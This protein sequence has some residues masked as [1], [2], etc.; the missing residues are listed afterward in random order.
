MTNAPEDLGRKNAKTGL[1][2]ASIAVGMVALSFAFVP[3]YRLFCQVTGLGGTPMVVDTNKTELSEHTI[4]VRFDSNVHRDLPWEFAPVQ[5]EVTVNLGEDRL[6]AYTSEN[7]SDVPV[8][9]ISNFNVTPLKAA[10]YFNKIQCFCFE[11]QTLQ[12]GQKMHMPVSFFVDPA[13]A[14]DPLAKDV[15]TIT[16][17]YTF[18]RSLDEMAEEEEKLAASG[19]N[20]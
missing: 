7:I 11:N 13:I 10:Q 20:Y 18:F 19:I 8:T 9:G 6:I 2:M 3:A 15:T 17:S 16:L 5:R 4:K 14:D 12:P 1:R